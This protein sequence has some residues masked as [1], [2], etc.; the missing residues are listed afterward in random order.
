LRRWTVCVLHYDIDNATEV[1]EMT[2]IIAKFQAMQTANTD[3]LT[4]VVSEDPGRCCFTVHIAGGLLSDGEDQFDTNSL[5]AAL[6]RASTE[7]AIALEGN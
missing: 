7:V 1:N 3:A 6:Q 5:Q 2:T 4:V